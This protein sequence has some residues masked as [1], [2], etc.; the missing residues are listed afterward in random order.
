MAGFHIQSFSGMV[1]RTDSR[2]LGNY[3][4]QIAYNCKLTS[5]RIGPLRAP[6][7]V[8]RPNIASTIRTIFR[9][10][11]GQNSY[12]MTWANEVNVA[13]SPIGQDTHK[14][15][16]YTGDGEPRMSTLANAISGGNQDYPKLFHVLGVTAPRTAPTVTPTGGTVTN[17]TRAYVYTYVTALG[18]ESAPSP[19]GSG[20]GFQDATWTISGMNAAPPNTGGIANITYSVNEVTVTTTEALHFAR[21]GERFTLAGVTTVTNVNGTWTL[22][23]VPA[24]N[25]FTFTA[26]TAPTGTYNNATDTADTW[27]RVAPHNTTGMV[28]RLYRAGTGAKYLLAKDNIPVATTGIVDNTASSALGVE[29]PSLDWDMPPADMHA[30]IEMP[31]GVLAGLS[32]N[33]VCLCEPYRPHAWPIDYRQSMHV[34]GRALGA[35]GNSLLVATEAEPYVMVGSNPASMS[36]TRGET[37]FPCVSARGMVD[38]GMGIIYPGHSGLVLGGQVITADLYTED[39][40]KLLN[41]SSMI[42]AMHDTRYYGAVT[43][44]DGNARLL[45]IDKS[46]QAQVLESNEAITAIYSDKIDGKLYVVQNNQ[47]MQWDASATK[48]LFDWWSKEIVFPEPANLGAAKVDA[49]FG[50]TEAEIAALQAAA[51]AINAANAQIMGQ[52]NIVRTATLANGSAVVTGLSSTSDLLRGMS[53]TGTGIPANTF[54]HSVDSFSQVTLDKNATASGAQS[55]TFTGSAELLDGAIAGAGLA[56][57]A[58]CGGR[59][60]VPEPPVYDIMEFKLYVDGQLK[61]SRALTNSDAFRLPSGYKSDNVSVRLSG[62][63]A[64]RRVVVAESMLGLKLA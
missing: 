35:Y 25:Q 17:E 8:L 55:L 10:A 24:A 13:R 28:K 32:G 7:F 20:T 6:Q 43:D 34:K 14:R 22:T 54:V 4:A 60:I 53:V 51:A 47:I 5:G 31:G 57:Y 27:T 16:Y 19:A 21:T 62:N 50:M 39:E 59:L 18:E 42:S 56:S 11:D 49:D 61:F 44:A 15:F 30:L 33:E 36:M 41:P 52:T 40:W 58:V 29:L 23:G 3:Q 48:L 45:I 63:V 2:L 38:G 9:L 46:E 64:V 1:P 26:T 12:W 37:Y